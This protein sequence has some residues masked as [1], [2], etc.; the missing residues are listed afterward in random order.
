M[1]NIYVPSFP[2]PRADRRAKTPGTAHE[3]PPPLA[4][5]PA[6]PS[7]GIGIGRWCG[8]IAGAPRACGVCSRPVGLFL[9]GV[10]VGGGWL[11]GLCYVL[12]IYIYAHT[13]IFMYKMTRLDLV[14][15]HRGDEGATAPIH[16]HPSTCTKI[17][18]NI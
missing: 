16:R 7:G 2:P 8:G 6:P 5:A 3:Q 1:I 14:A 4:P 13:Q 11:V 9:V 10:C 18:Y 12:R 17:Y 15:V